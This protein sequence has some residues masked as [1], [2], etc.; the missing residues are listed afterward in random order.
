[1]AFDPNTFVPT[2][3]R[4]AA[5]RLAAPAAVS[6]GATSPGPASPGPASPGA[7][8]EPYQAA[9]RLTHCGKSIS[10]AI[11]ELIGSLHIPYDLASSLVWAEMSSPSVRLPE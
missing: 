4:I 11:D 6:P 5:A 1:M 2:P 10:E 3:G 9:W 7:T 8:D